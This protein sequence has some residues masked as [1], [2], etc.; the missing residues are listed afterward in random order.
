MS[1]LAAEVEYVIGVD[2][3][4]DTN[5]AAIVTA[6]GAVVA[7]QQCSTDAMGYRR[8]VAFADEQAAGR[9]VWAIEGSGSFGSG[10]TTHLLER[11]E[12]AARSTA[13]P[14]RR[15]ATAPRPTTWTPYAPPAK[16]SLVTT[17]PRR[18]RAV[19]VKRCGSCSP[20]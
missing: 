15:G 1:M 16:P 4:R 10:L 17:W 20:R 7:H 11:G 5:T 8:V 18:G 3:H 9:R 19:T 12:W 13:Q 6:A 2:T 14:A